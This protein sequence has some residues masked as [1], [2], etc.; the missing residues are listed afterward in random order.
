MI[1]VLHREM[2]RI[3]DGVSPAINLLH[4]TKEIGG[5][6]VV[7]QVEGMTAI[8]IVVR[9]VTVTDGDV[10]HHLV[11]IDRWQ[12]DRAGVV[13]VAVEMTGDGTTGPVVTISTDVTE[14]LTGPHE[15]MIA[16]TA[17]WTVVLRGIGSTTVRRETA[18]LTAVIV[19]W[20][21]DLVI[22]IE[23]TTDHNRVTVTLTEARGIVILTDETEILTVLHET[24]T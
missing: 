4:E 15:T 1:V 10:V 12:V 23:T 24:A 18:T 22:E 13:E 14:T 5:Q 19:I 11:M 17:T 7:R 16:V 8:G 20:T 6:M 9:Q 2:S 3:H 21:E